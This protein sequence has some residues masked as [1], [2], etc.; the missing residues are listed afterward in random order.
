MKRKFK[1]SDKEYKMTEELE[2]LHVLHTHG[3]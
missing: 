3:I 1:K 2:S